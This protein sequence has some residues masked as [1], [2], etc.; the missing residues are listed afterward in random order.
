LAAPARFIAWFLFAL[1]I[2]I[3]LV[4]LPFVAWLK[5]LTGG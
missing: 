2:A 1:L 3:S 5:M 4:I